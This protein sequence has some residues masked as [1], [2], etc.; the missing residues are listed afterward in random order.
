MSDGFDAIAA[1]DLDAVIAQVG[2]ALAEL[3][4]ASIFV[5]GG[6]GFFG[7][8]LLALLA[9]A[10]TSLRLDLAIT[11]LSRDPDA[12]A[13][14]S[15][16]LARRDGVRLI[17]G[18]IRSFAFPDGHFTH[19]V[20]AATDTS[21]AADRDPMT[22]IATIT[23]GTRRVLD[24]S[25]SAGVNRFLYVSSGAIYG[26]Q[27]PELAA[28][29]ED[30]AGACDPLDPRSA[31]GQAKRLAEQMCAIASDRTGMSAIIARAFAFVG[32]GLPLDGHFAIGKLHPRRRGR[33]ADHRVRRRAAA[34]L[35][36]LHGG[37]RGLASDAPRARRVRHGLQRR[38]GPRD[39][40]RRSGRSGRVG[41]PS[42]RGVAIRGV[43]SP[44]ERARS[45][46]VPSIDRA[47]RDLGLDVW[48]PL[49]EAIRR[50]ADAARRTG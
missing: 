25:A 4:G 10:R 19:V 20:H 41:V 29:P 30:H 45:R 11:V 27:P 16:D 15:P 34:P 28:I 1:G 13:V 46:Y 3:D 7:R 42:S 44:R 33:P 2:P 47:R 50:T 49:D 40:H 23:E 17:A 22:L 37:S 5:T 8:W 21:A 43:A 36:P 39:Q 26:R 31:Y 6:T 32:P 12:F 38:L 48:T 24:F 9:R 18:D 35:L 14:A